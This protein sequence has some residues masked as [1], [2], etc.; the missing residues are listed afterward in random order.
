MVSNI[1][2]YNLENYKKLKDIKKGD[3]INQDD[4]PFVSLV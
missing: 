2:I 1:M 4:L 3:E